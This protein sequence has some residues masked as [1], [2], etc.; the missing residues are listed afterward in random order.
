VSIGLSPAKEEHILRVYENRVLRR[1]SGHKRQ[2]QQ[3]NGE[4]YIIRNFVT[5]T[6]PNLI[7]AVKSMRVRWTGHEVTTMHTK[8]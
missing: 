2:K 3:E 4:N 7:R 5:C 1:I 8:F 6:L